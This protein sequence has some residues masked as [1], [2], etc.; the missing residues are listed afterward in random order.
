MQNSMLVRRILK[1]GLRHRTVARNFEKFSNGAAAYGPF[2]VK[3]AIGVAVAGAGGNFAGA[4]LAL[5][6]VTLGF[7]AGKKDCTCP[8][9]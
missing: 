5:F 2:A 4:G 6:G 3:G 8:S 1:T 9:H 7:Q